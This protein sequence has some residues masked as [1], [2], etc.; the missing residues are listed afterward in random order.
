MTLRL[1]TRGSALARAQ[2]RWLADHV[3]QATGVTV[4]LVIIKTRGDR[5]V[6]RPLQQV[7]GKGLFT[8]EIEEAQLVN[9][10]DFAVHSMKDLPTEEPEGLVVAAIPKRADPRDV[11]VGMELSAL[12]QGA[13]VGTGS[14]RRALQLRALR[15]DIEIRGIRGNVDTRVRKQRDGDYDAVVVAAAGLNRLGRGNEADYSFSVEEMIPAVGQGAL[16]VQ[17][18]AENT[19]VRDLLRQVADL[20]TEQCVAAERSFLV[21]MEGGCSVPAGCYAWISGDQLTVRGFFEDSGAK[22]VV[23]SVT[24]GDSLGRQLADM[25]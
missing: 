13:V 12:A 19:R 1:G 6:D 9:E 21:A 5:I 25:M 14:L 22:E 17:C 20:E 11:L 4:A 16:A 8:K 23:G 7:G 24:D 3:E 2:S 15:P 10:V 18:R